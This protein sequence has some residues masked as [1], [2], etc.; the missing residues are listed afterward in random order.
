MELLDINIIYEILDPFA[1][2]T[3]WAYSVRGYITAPLIVYN[4]PV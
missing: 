1:V 2:D 4:L 3:S